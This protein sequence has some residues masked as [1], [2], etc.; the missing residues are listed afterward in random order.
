MQRREFLLYSAAAY[1]TANA[2]A[3]SGFD[4]PFGSAS[5][6]ARAIAKKQVSAVELTRHCL[7]RL[8][9]YDSSLHAFVQVYGDWSLA[10]AKEADAAL[11]RKEIWG[12]LHG[13]PVSIKECLAYRETVTSAGIPALKDFKPTHNAALVDR[14]EKGGAIIVGKTNVPLALSDYQAFNDVYAVTSN[15]PYDRTRTPGGSTGGGAAAM[16]AGLGYLTFG[17]DIGGSI[18][19]PAHFCGLYGHKPT[20]DLVP[21]R[22]H[23]PPMADQT[24]TMPNLLPVAGPLARSADDLKLALQ[25]VGGPDGPDAKGLHYSMPKPRAGRLKDFRVGVPPDDSWC[26]LSS[27]IRSCYE[28]AIVEIERSG[29]KVA[30]GWPAGFQLENA[31]RVYTYLVFSA[32]MSPLSKDEEEQLRQAYEKDPQDPRLAARFGPAS[33]MPTMVQQL[34]AIRGIWETFFQDF[35]VFLSPVDFVA[36]FPHDHSSG[37][38]LL[39]TPEGPRSY[40][41]QVRWLFFQTLT[42]NPATVAP[43]GR[44]ASGLPCGIQIMGPFFEDATSISFAGLMRERLGGFVPPKGFG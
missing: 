13:V 5:G 8:A 11:A 16:A 40:W 30:R 10:R 25:V 28:D 22:G 43:A 7:D 34:Y 37:T 32:T 21:L 27:E 41:D 26:P 24:L 23:V 20:I 15:N 17:S 39:Q 35:D 38:R 12:P 1:K 42:G 36:A 6:A 4:D 29:A 14:L 3:Q 2:A 31:F 44:T 18:R 9:R 33:E 19:V